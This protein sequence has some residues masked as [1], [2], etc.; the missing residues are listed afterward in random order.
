MDRIKYAKVVAILDAIHDLD[1]ESKTWTQGDDLLDLVD[2]LYDVSDLA[3]G[4]AES[5]RNVVGVAYPE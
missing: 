4:V 1:T 3:K 2:W 5:K